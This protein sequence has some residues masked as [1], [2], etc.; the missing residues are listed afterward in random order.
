MAKL[1]S[2]DRGTIEYRPNINF[3]EP[4]ADDDPIEGLKGPDMDIEAANEQLDKLDRLALAGDLLADALQARVDGKVGDFTVK[5]DKDIDKPVIDA[6]RRKFGAGPPEITF[7]Q[8]RECRENMRQFGIDKANQ[9]DPS[10]DDIKDG[11]T[12]PQSPL[13]LDVNSAD[14]KG[15]LLRPEV[16]P[17]IQVI[18]PVDIDEFTEDM[19]CL[20]MNILWQRFIRPILKIVIPPP[21]GFLLPEDICNSE[22]ETADEEDLQRRAEQALES[23][24]GSTSGEGEE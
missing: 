16:Q 15:G 9:L 19:E 5:L 11:R 23:F 18:P 21:F 7:Q 20:L 4:R 24:I 8:Y 13:P 10:D 22:G 1:S 17:K 6:L 2:T 12:D 3:V 14:A